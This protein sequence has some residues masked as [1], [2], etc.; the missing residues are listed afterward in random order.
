KDVCDVMTN[1]L[2]KPLN[3]LKVD[4][5]ACRNNFLMQFQSDLLDCRIV[6]PKVVE[7]TA[8]GAA[9]LAGVTI[10]LWRKKDL[11]SLN[12][13]N[14]VFYP[15]MKAAVRNDLYAGWAM[16]LRKAQSQ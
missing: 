10:G 13:P 11:M 2:G 3:E 15:K 4:G 9:F 14:R 16:A 6:R 5:G 7:S 1:E 12:K 8:Q